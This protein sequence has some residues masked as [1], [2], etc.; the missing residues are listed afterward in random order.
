MSETEITCPPP[1]KLITD[2]GTGLVRYRMAFTSLRVSP[3]LDGGRTIEVDDDGH[4]VTFDLTRDQA[5][6]FASLLSSSAR[7]PKVSS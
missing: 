1:N 6:H 2:G 4:V 3:R 5:Q 7:G